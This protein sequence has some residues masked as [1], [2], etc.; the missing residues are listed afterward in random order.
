MAS[1]LLQ[2]GSNPHFLIREGVKRL[3]DRLSLEEAF[4]MAGGPLAL[5]P[6]QPVAAA[7]ATAVGPSQPL[8]QIPSEVNVPLVGHQQ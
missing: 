8:Q 4:P 6:Q 3:D 1:L 7:P 2:A 5:P